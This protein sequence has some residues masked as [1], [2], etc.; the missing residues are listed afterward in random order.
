MGNLRKASENDITI[1]LDRTDPESDTITVHEE[2]DKRQRNALMSL[3][4]TRPDVQ[5]T[6]LTLAEGTEFQTALFRALV[7]GWSADMPCTVDEYL[8]LD[9]TS[10]NLIDMALALHFQTMIPTKVESGKA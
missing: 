3:M 6:G 8:G 7:V 4:P 2:L 10:A 1:P 5:E 9:T